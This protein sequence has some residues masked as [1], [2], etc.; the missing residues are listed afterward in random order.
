MNSKYIYLL[1]SSNNLLNNKKFKLCKN[2]PRPILLTWQ[3]I[4][5]IIKEKIYILSILKLT[6]W[7]SSD[8]DQKLLDQIERKHPESTHEITCL[9]QDLV[10]KS[11]TVTTVFSFQMQANDE[12]A[13]Q[14]SQYLASVILNCHPQSSKFL[15][16]S[17]YS[18]FWYDLASLKL[19][20]I[21]PSIVLW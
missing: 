4:L 8:I 17:Y 2:V 20:E 9:S 21:N 15:L 5:P 10:N 3:G 13:K 19:L 14:L 7:V 18:Q 12:I 1:L 11:E 16:S 6:G